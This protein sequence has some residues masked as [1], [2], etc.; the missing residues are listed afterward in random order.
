[1]S[2]DEAVIPGFSILFVLSF[3]NM[4]ILLKLSLTP[5]ELSELRLREYGLNTDAKLP[6]LIGRK[7]IQ[8]HKAGVF[9]R[10]GLA[11]ETTE[12]FP[13][14]ARVSQQLCVNR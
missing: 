6:P 3:P 10:M 9:T 13:K 12:E 8:T 2:G 5:T 7:T 1:L 11:E 4:T 14:R